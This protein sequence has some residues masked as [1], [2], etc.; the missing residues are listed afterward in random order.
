MMNDRQR[1][2]PNMNFDNAFFNSAVKRTL[3]ANRKT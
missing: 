2:L 1:T 3:V